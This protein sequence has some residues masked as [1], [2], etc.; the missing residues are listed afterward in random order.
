MNSRIPTGNRIEKYIRQRQVDLIGFV[1]SRC[2]SRRNSRDNTIFRDAP[3]NLPSPI[4]QE[5]ILN[6][7]KSLTDSF[8]IVLQE[9]KDET[10][11]NDL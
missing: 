5:R 9:D 3:L 7:L 6:S 11:E 4:S 10:L 2:V 8:D 1:R